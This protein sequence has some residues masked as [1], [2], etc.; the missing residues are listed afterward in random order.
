[1]KFDG[2]W[3]MKLVGDEVG[4]FF[5]KC[6]CCVVVEVEGNWDVVVM[7]QLG[8]FLFF[9]LFDLVLKFVWVGCLVWSIR[10]CYGEGEDD[11][12]V[13]C[14]FLEVVLLFGV[15]IVEVKVKVV[16]CVGYC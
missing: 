14:L 16:G 1:M 10:W 2:N 5:G 6:V 9:G 15:N 7:G 13:E 12:F 11:F 3:G 8:V 4:Y